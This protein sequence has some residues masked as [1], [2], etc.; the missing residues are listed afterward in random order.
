MEGCPVLELT[1]E[2]SDQVFVFVHGTKDGVSR[3]SS[4]SCNNS[5]EP[6]ADIPAKRTYLFP[7]ARFADSDW[8][9]V[10]AIAVS[11]SE[12][13][14]QFAKLLQALPDA[15][16]NTAGMR[17]DNNGMDQW[18]GKLDRLVAT[19]SDHAVWTA[20]RIP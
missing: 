18:L 4:G 11:G 3:L 1:V 20:R 8:P 7:A 13:S 19:N 5:S 12:L 6:P 14:S 16:G 2:Q 10:Y 9:T 17:A 15:C